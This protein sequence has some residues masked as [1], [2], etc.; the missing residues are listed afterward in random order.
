MKKLYYAAMYEIT[1]SI[2]WYVID[3]RN[4]WNHWWNVSERY[5]KLRDNV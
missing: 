3:D 2:M 1:D 4:H 5:R